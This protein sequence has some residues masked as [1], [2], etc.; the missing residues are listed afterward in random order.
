M[1]AAES[2]RFSGQP[3]NEAPKS[4]GFELTARPEAG[5]AARRALRA[6]NEAL[7]PSVRD[8]VLLLVTELVTNAVRH[9]DAGPERTVRVEL[10]QWPRLL[11]V[12]V[13]DEGT[14]FTAHPSPRPLDDSGGWGLHL[15]HEIADRWAVSPT[16]SGTCVWFDIAYEP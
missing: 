7:P 15:V 11:A 1:S 4:F 2:G 12:A 9:A 16:R 14:G 13:F 10:R 5:A 8:D 3:P 6:G